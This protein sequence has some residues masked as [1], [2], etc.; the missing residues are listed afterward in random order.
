[1]K[2]SVMERSPFFSNVVYLHEIGLVKESQINIV[3]N[4]QSHPLMNINLILNL[5]KIIFLRLNE[6]YRMLAEFLRM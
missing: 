1:M 4:N 3:E 6:N 5:N 2:R